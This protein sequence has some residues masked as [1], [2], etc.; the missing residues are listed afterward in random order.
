MERLAQLGGAALSDGELLGILIGTG[1]GGVNAVALGRE[2]LGRGGSLAG[3]ERMQM[4]ELRRLP[5]LGL[6]KAARIVAALTLARRL[7]SEVAPAPLIDSAAKAASY[8]SASMA[9]LQRERLVVLL[10]DTRHRL[11]R[12]IIVTEGSTN[13]LSVHPRDVFQPAVREMATGVLVAHNHP[14]GD[15]QPSREDDGL[16]A[17][18]QG[19]GELLGIPLVDHVIMGAGG[20]YFSYVEQRRL[21][22]NGS[23]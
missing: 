18:L 9:R 3:V 6:A 11:L 15:P 21:H 23:N 7:N 8:L 20:R 2:V 16:T 1:V 13:S 19:V 5:G 22:P 12:E 14:G 17:R 10:L 4:G